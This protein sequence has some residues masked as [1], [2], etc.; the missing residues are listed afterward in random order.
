MVV[1]VAAMVVFMVVVAMVTVIV[2]VKVVVVVICGLSHLTAKFIVGK[3][4]TRDLRTDRRTNPT[5]HRDA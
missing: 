5:S 2:V 1:V 4:I 3:Q